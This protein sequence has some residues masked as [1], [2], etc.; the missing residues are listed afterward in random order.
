MLLLGAKKTAGVMSRQLSFVVDTA[1]QLSCLSSYF[2][3]GGS[4]AGGSAAGAESPAG[5]VSL[6]PGLSLL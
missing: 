4:A 1:F 2:S 3:A 6:L 5:S